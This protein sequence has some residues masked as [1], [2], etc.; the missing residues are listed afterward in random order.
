MSQFVSEAHESRFYGAISCNRQKV[1]V[2]WLIT[3][4]MKSWS[5]RKSFLLGFKRKLFQDI[6]HVRKIGLRS[7]NHQN[8]RLA[9]CC[10]CIRQLF[11]GFPFFAKSFHQPQSKHCDKNHQQK[12]TTVSTLWNNKLPRVYRGPG[13][14]FFGGGRRFI[15]F[16]WLCLI[17]GHIWS[18]FLMESLVMKSWCLNKFLNLEYSKS[19][20]LSDWD[21]LH[22]SLRAR[23]SDR[24]AAPLHHSWFFCAYGLRCLSMQRLSIWWETRR[25]GHHENFLIRLTPCCFRPVAGINGQQKFIQHRKRWQIFMDVFLSSHL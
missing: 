23:F 25:I 15:K 5:T 13:L 18:S 20:K 11:R 14:L 1:R 2:L 4:V 8:N 16:P 17:S 7:E 12:T 3:V 9:R 22:K 24:P 21:N 19:P 10:F 6:M